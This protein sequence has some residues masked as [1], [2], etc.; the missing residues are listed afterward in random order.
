MEAETVSAT[1]EILSML[2]STAYDRRSF[3]CILS[4]RN[5]RTICSSQP[6]AHC[7]AVILLFMKYPLYK[8]L[9][10]LQSRSGHRL[11]EKSFAPA[12]DRTLIARSSSP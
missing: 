9:G 4:H 12:G 11:E 6:L 5:F 10:G 3:R 1:L 2:Y 8:R 7:E